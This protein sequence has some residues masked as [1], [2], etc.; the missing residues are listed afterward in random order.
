MKA[1]LICKTPGVRSSI[2][3]PLLGVLAAVFAASAPAVAQS[4]SAGLKATVTVKVQKPLQLTALRNLA[5]G[6]VL[7]GTYNGADTVTISP[8]GRICGTGGGLTCSGVFSTAQ[9]RVTGS[10]NQVALISSPTPTV[11]LANGSGGTLSL[12]PTFPSSVTFDNSGN[13]GKL[14]EVGG[15][16]TFASNMPDGIY[17]GTLDIQVA[18][19]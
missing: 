6:T 12:T 7:V 15:R 19:Q 11:T 1:L 2:V 5:F 3:L 9:F 10:N 13:Q 18:Y 14:F 8:S 17:T 16:L 4:N